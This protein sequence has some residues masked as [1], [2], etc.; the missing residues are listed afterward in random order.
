[1]GGV[2]LGQLVLSLPHEGV[3]NEPIPPKL[4][5]NVVH[6]VVLGSDMRVRVGPREGFSVPL[7]GVPQLC[8]VAPPAL[9]SLTLLTTQPRAT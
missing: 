8:A 5:R 1:M 2:V 4:H 6:V 7:D 9:P 3:E